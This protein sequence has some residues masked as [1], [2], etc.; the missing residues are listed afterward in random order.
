MALESNEDSPGAL[1][2][3]TLDAPDSFASIDP[4][5]R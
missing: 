4:P 5:C 1:G 3:D 2:K